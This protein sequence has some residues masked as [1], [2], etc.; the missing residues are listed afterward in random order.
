MFYQ[1]SLETQS[2]YADNLP[3]HGGQTS[4]DFCGKDTQYI[5]MIPIS[6]FENS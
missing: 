4:S 3:T 1:V 6:D 5:H 2:S